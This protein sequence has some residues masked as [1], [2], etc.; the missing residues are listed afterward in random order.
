MSKALRPETLSEFTG[1]PQLRHD[2]ELLIKAARERGD[3]PDH[4]LLA[5]P[6]GL[7][8]TT[9]ASI[10][11]RE[12]QQPLVTTSAPALARPGDLLA[13]LTGL[14]EPTVVFV[15]EIHA[16][17]RKTEELLY[18]A[19]ED[20][21]VD[22]I[23]GE[24]AAARSLRIG[25]SPFTLVG[26]TTHMGLLSAPLR[27][28]F[29]FIGRLE[30][31]S[32][33]ELSSIVMRTASILEVDI[34]HEGARV[35]AS[36]SRGTPRVA[37]RWTRRVRDWVQV[38]AKES[39]DAQAATEALDSYGIDD[40]GLDQLGRDILTTVVAHFG[41]GPAGMSAIA[42]AVGEP[43]ATITAVYEPALMSHGLWQRTPRGRVVT[44][45]GYAHLGLPKASTTEQPL[46]A[47]WDIPNE[48]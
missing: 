21:H 10:V 42:A 7:G 20:G 37:N 9:L 25:I 13:L 11:A 40:K 18:S 30:P 14:T 2:L 38:H 44:E 41:G 16:L 6:P 27:D 34:D 47:I 5:G 3:N 4:I 32:E 46:P 29:G 28:R 22:L 8:K 12:L 48:R 15:D 24:R 43:E 17:D 26:A 1:Q 23:V 35:I 39:I 45:A 19:L 36:R 33:E 31:Y